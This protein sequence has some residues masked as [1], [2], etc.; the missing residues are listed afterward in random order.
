MLNRPG[1][2]K[3]TLLEPRM[4][5]ACISALTFGSRLELVCLSCWIHGVSGRATGALGQGSDT[6]FLNK[7]NVCVLIF[8]DLPA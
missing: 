4:V 3:G 5:P 1:T 2:Q 6:S 7:T 8:G